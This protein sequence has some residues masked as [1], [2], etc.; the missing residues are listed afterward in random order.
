MLTT[1]APGTLFVS[2]VIK[3]FVTGYSQHHLS[4]LNQ[5]LPKK[6]EP[7]ILTARTKKLSLKNAVSLRMPANRVYL[8]KY[9]YQAPINSHFCGS[10]SH[11]LLSFLRPYVDI[12]WQTL[13]A[14]MYI[15]TA[16]SFLS[17]PDQNNYTKLY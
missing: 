10:R 11:F 9:S 3:L 6:S 16:H 1:P 2:V 15:E 8:K 13:G 7:F 14:I 17:N 5:N 12:C 4:A